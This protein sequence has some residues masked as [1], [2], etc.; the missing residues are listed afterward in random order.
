MKSEDERHSD[1][2]NLVEKGGAK[3]VNSGV[4]LFHPPQGLNLP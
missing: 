2:G 3:E 4:C 1:K